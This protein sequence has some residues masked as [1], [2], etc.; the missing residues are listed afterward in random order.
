MVSWPPDKRAASNSVTATVPDGELVYA[1]GVIHG[2]MD[3]LSA[4]LALIGQD[5]VRSDHANKTLIFLGDYVDRG[6][7]SRG[8]IERLSEG[9]PDGF[10][11]HFLKGNHEQF[12]LDFLQ[13]PKWLAPWRGN[14]GDPT[15]LSYGVDVG[16]LDR[17]SAPS[18]A[19]RAAFAQALPD[20]HLKFLQGL[21]LNCVIGDYV[22]VHAGLRPGVPL[23][24]QVPADLLWIRN[25]FLDAQEPFGKVVVHGHTPERKP[26][27]RENRIGIDTGAVF[28]GCLT[29]LRL[30]NGTQDFLQAAP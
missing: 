20:R 11:A 21:G 12:L 28:T 24:D 23:S 17:V 30:A 16:R 14:G 2:R 5:A 1:I 26:V 19:W 13:D 8:V 29:A 9:L 22:F 18:E 15:L 3:L 7:D 10:E 27:V 4:L 6:P 25:E